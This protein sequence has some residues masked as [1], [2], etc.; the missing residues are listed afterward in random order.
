MQ[1][2]TQR[3]VTRIVKV[4]AYLGLL[5]TL[6][7]VVAAGF[8]VVVAVAVKM[9]RLKLSFTSRQKQVTRIIKILVYLG[10]L[11]TLLIVVVVV[12][13]V[14]VDDVVDDVVV[15]DVVVILNADFL[16][17][18]KVTCTSIQRHVTIIVTVVAFVGQL[19]SLL[20]LL[21]LFMTLL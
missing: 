2:S 9:W 20:L 16:Y 14:V 17:S 5:L 6:L 21:L 18:Q 15:D 13:D 7:Y 8:A 19:L 10:L 11:L 12:D 1:E 4:V 3:H